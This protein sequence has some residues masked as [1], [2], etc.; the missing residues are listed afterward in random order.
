MVFK[1]FGKSLRALGTGIEKMGFSLQGSTAFREELSRHR[2]LMPLNG[3]KPKLGIKAWIAPNAA[4]IGRVEIGDRTSIFYGAVLRG[5]V[6]KISIGSDTHIG[7]RVMIHAASDES[8]NPHPTFID[9]NV[10]VEPG[11]ILHACTVK[12]FAKIGLGAVILDGAVVGHN[13]ILTPGS[14]LPQGKQIPDGEV[15]SGSPAKFVR[16]TTGDEIEAIKAMLTKLAKLSQ[17][18]ETEH[19]KSREQRIEEEHQP[20]MPRRHIPGFLE[21][22][23]ETKPQK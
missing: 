15:W 2:R 14:L 6:N 21:L 16:K 12:S 3:L 22:E 4:V 13:S 5:D 7:D 1:L 20:L 17:L 19:A 11:A 9:N 8:G 18:H 23:D 10:I